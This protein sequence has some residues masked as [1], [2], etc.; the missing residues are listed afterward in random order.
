MLA[1]CLGTMVLVIFWCG[2]AV[3]TGVDPVATALAFGL[4]IVALAYAIWPVSWCHVNP[5]VSLWVWMTGG[6]TAKDFW[7]Y[8]L[9]QF[10]GW[11]LG[12]LLLGVMLGMNFSALWANGLDGVNGNIWIGLLVEVVLTFV[13]VMAVLWATSTS[14]NGSVAGIVIWFALTLVHLLWLWFTGTSVNPARSFGPALFQNGAFGDV[15][16]FIVA[17]LVGAALAACVFKYLTSK[18]K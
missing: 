11:I 15:W 17:P 4:V 1:E 3:W 6:M 10:V 12:A 16:I 2:V 9:A 8:V 5:A 14:E 18:S 7:K 13:F